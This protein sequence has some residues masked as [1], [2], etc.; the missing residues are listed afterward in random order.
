M[1]KLCSV[2]L[3][4]VL[5]CSGI[6]A[7]AFAQG[8][9]TSGVQ[10]K[11]AH[12]LYVST[13]GRDNGD[14][15][16]QNPFRTIERARNAVRTLD[17]TK[18]DI[19]VKIAGGTYYLDNTIV[20]TE[21]DSGNEDCTIYY[22]AMDV[23]KPVISG[24]EKVT[25][26]WKDEGNGTYSIPYERDI[27]LRSLYVNGE[28][29]YM[30]QKES[31]G[32]GNYGSY[33]VD[34]KA[35]WA[36]ISGTT[37]AGTQLDAGAIPLDTRNQDDIELMTQTTWNTAIVCVDNLQDI[38]N[39]RISA[40]YQMPYGAVAQQPS[41][42]N[43][44]KSDG[45]QMMYNVFEWL[46][47]AKGHFY[48][49]KTA[50][51][52]YYCPRDGEDMSNLEVIAPKLETLVDL[53]GSSTTSRIGY[54]TF[55]GL[56]FAHSDW[57]LYELEG[58]YG[59]VTVQGAAGL[60][61]FADG[62]WHP[63]IY[64]AYDVGPGAVMVNS[65]QHIAFYGNTICHT[66][67]DGLSFVN[68]VVDSAASGNLIYDTAGSGFL[69]GHPQ[70]VYIGDKGS[71][72]G[73][74]SEKEKYDVGVEGACKRI[75]LTNNFIS[76]TCLMFWGDSGV[77]VFLAE[78]FEMKYNHLQNTPY[79]GIS[80]G[81]GWWNMDGSAEAVVPGV[82]METTKNNTIMYNTF[83]NTI[84]KLGDT[85]AIYTLGD[86]PGTVISE[87][88]IW[89]IGT[90]GVDP[91]YHIRGIHPDEG[92]RHVYGEKNV[93]EI[94][95][96]FTCIDCSSWGKNGYNTWDNNYA[97]SSS[98]SINETWEE[99]TVVTNAHT[100]LDGIWGTD[101]FDIVKNAGIQSD[102][103]SIIPE[104]MF[105]L[106][107]RLLPNKIRATGQEL[108]WGTAADNIEGEIWL[109]PENTE[110][111]V[112]SDTIVKVVNGKVKVP[113]AEGIYKV[114]IVNGSKISAPSSGQII[115]ETDNS[116]EPKDL[117]EYMS[118]DL[119]DKPIGEV[120]QDDA[121]LG[122]FKNGGVYV[123]AED[124]NK[125]L[126]VRAAD[127]G[128]GHHGFYLKDAE[129]SE[130]VI[131]LDMKFN[132]DNNFT[133]DWESVSV[134][135]FASTQGGKEQLSQKES[136]FA[137][138]Y[139]DRRNQHTC[140]YNIGN[141]GAHTNGSFLPQQIN[142]NVWYHMKIMIRGGDYFVKLWEKNGSEPEEWQ[143][144]QELPKELGADGTLRVITYKHNQDSVIDVSFDNIVVSVPAAKKYEVRYHA[145][146][147]SYAPENQQKVHG[148]DLTLTENQ[149]VRNGYIFEGW[150]TSKDGLG[151][152]YQAG[153]VYSADEDITLYAKWRAVPAVSPK[154]SGCINNTTMTITVDNLSA[155]Y[156]YTYEW[157]RGSVNGEKVGSSSASYT[158]PELSLIHI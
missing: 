7:A 37:A 26:D 9:E 82:P 21:A 117:E 114:Y 96:W 148:S 142:K 58:S 5:L 106:Q 105:G 131:N 103:Y 41:W 150:N 139:L 102:Y 69:L 116:E 49:D 93:I 3:A 43:N 80:I 143:L 15:T 104:S 147:G 83:K 134:Q 136:L 108:D 65:A 22:E 88:Y 154:L 53:S 28:R 123:E 113:D 36:W 70:H 135:G 128:T 30:T 16:E 20:F 112:E 24:G 47:G 86:M 145:N 85:G 79:S 84:T 153:A 71:D 130:A 64:R 48:F 2:L 17:K 122:T 119:E 137:G 140:H 14:G 144:Y 33:T 149:A 68:D 129:Y 156:T 94:S 72:Y 39:G 90:P 100:S 157:H 74:L 51:R 118:V 91:S 110:N 19:V 38:G 125:V 151:T 124:G 75:K 54:I 126:R 46:P 6:P 27:K 111:F 73:L 120:T 138:S 99:G 50:K 55:S 4:V 98:Y 95:S 141:E 42:N 107:D 87:N 89:S 101:V 155:E 18:G 76:D 133:H 23:E 67:N 11:A 1:K 81:W 61:Y 32:R 10:R 62:N 8:T 115:V 52:L 132:A 63:S 127:G 29:A 12:T 44:Y 59:R 66:G 78:E 77:M 45:W 34:G 92:T 146:G 35:D 97:T 109:A 57:N 152:N 158:A 13:D 31:Q 40:N 121:Q 56:E 25:G 60:I